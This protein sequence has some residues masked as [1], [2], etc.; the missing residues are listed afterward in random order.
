[1]RFADTNVLLYAISKKPSE[2]AKAVRAREILRS[3]DLGVSV[4]VLQEFYVQDL[5]DEQDIYGVR[6]VNPFR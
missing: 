6:V 2:R 3:R 5:N 1:M 4:Q